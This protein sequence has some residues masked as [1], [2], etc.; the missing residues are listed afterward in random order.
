ML[1]AH[2]LCKQAAQVLPAPHPVILVASEQLV[3]QPLFPYENYVLNQRFH[4]VKSLSY[5]VI[6]II[7]HKLW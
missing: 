3:R 4:L 5:A 7:P 1:E 2:R 6:G